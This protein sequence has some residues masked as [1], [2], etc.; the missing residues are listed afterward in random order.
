MLG[1]VVT[2][3]LWFLNVYPNHMWQSKPFALVG[4]LTTAVP[5]DPAS[6]NDIAFEPRAWHDDISLPTAIHLQP[7]YQAQQ[8]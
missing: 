1:A 2:E 5:E 3:L 7:R 8:G 6:L 4:F